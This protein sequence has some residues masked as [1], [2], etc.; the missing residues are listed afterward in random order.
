MA[1]LCGYRE[2]RGEGSVA[3]E[4][5]GE[6]PRQEPKLVL[7]ELHPGIRYPVSGMVWYGMVCHGLRAEQLNDEASTGRPRPFSLLGVGLLVSNMFGGSGPSI[8]RTPTTR[9]VLCILLILLHTFIHTTLE[10]VCMHTRVIML[11]A[12]AVCDALFVHTY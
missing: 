4:E 6:E 12:W 11:D 8:K 10:V 9:L 3:G 5:G 2:G 7:L 1:K